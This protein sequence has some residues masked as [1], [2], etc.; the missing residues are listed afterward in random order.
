MNYNNFPR[1]DGFPYN[2]IIPKDVNYT[3]NNT[4]VDVKGK[5]YKVNFT[6]KD[7]ELLNMFTKN[8]RAYD[9]VVFRRKNETKS[10]ALAELKAKA[11]K[12]ES[13]CNAVKGGFTHKEKPIKEDKKSS[14]ESDEKNN[15]KI[16]LSTEDDCQ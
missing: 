5:K 7:I 9:S 12:A 2:K 6:P 3:V 11:I 15:T 8:Y 4:F 14:F 1:T 16:H 13:F 10:L